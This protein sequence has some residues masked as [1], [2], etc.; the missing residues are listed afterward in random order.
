M[1]SRFSLA[2]APLSN[3]HVNELISPSVG[4]GLFPHRASENPPA[5]SQRRQ[6]REIIK[7][8]SEQGLKPKPSHPAMRRRHPTTERTLIP[9]HMLRR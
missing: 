8:R 1:K 3:N 9:A 5:R 4:A 7:M 2:A 6:K